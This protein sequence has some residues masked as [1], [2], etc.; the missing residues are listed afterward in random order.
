L[1]LLKDGVV[2]ANAGHFPRE[3]N[4]A[5]ISQPGKIAGVEAYE[6]D[7]ASLKL[8]DGCSGHLPGQGHRLNLAG[9]G[10]PGNSIEVMDMGFMLQTLCLAAVANGGVG[11][12]HCAVPIP[13]VITA[14]ITADINARMAETFQALALRQAFVPGRKKEFCPSGLKRIHGLRKQ[15]FP[16]TGGRVRYRGE[17]NGSVP[18]LKRIQGLRDQVSLFLIIIPGGGDIYSLRPDT[19]LPKKVTPVHSRPARNGSTASRNA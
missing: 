4:A 19:G 9:S 13:A 6:D 2:L 12:E 3:N 11:P 17:R 18:R 16:G 14:D 5:G 10:L 8:T 1:A 15:L 7:T